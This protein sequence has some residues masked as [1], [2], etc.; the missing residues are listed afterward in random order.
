MTDH[1]HKWTPGLKGRI[2]RCACG[3]TAFRV[4][5]AKS[6]E[7]RWWQTLPVFLATGVLIFMLIWWVA[8]RV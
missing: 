2:W 1:E 7:R 5:A 8:G 4:T 6:P 3:A